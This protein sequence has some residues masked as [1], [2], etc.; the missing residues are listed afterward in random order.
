MAQSEL[1]SAGDPHSEETGETSDPLSPQGNDPDPSE[2][3]N[4]KKA[5]ANS[6]A[7]W[8]TRFFAGRRASGSSIRENLSDALIQHGSDGGEFTPEEKLMLHNIL[9]LQ[10]V[11]VED[12]MI[13]RADIEA[14]DLSTTLGELLK[15]FENSGHSRM[16]VFDET[17]D[18]P[19]GI[20]HIR[21]VMGYITRTSTVGRKRVKTASTLDLTKVDL[22]RELSKLNL[23]RKVIFTPP[24]MLAADLMARMQASRMQMALVIDEYGGTEGLISLE[25]I[26]ELIVGDIEDEHDD[27]EIL[28]TQNPDGTL[29]VDARADIGDLRQA[30]E[31]VLDVEDHDEY[32]ESIG[33]VI[34]S[35]LGRVPVKGEVIEAFGYEFRIC[36]ADPRRIK[37]LEVVPSKKAA[38]RKAIPGE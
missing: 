7:G 24:S 32:A 11:R 9:R 26:V 28:I 18:D 33:G 27:D 19:R 8:L 22:D 20:I 35:L 30:L 23:V 14:V 36:D 13:P 37:T 6:K 25:D 2:Q 31:G 5:R 34:F 3:T 10:D 21:D 38:N 15:L 1:I 29:L 12:L 16:P 4:S 17:L